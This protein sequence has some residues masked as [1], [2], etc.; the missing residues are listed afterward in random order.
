MN[1]Q[2]SE[3]IKN[4]SA[5]LA[6]FHQAVGVIAKSADNPFFKSKYADLSSILESIK[7]PLHMA[8]LVFT[9]LP[10]GTNELTTFL[11]DVASG[12]FFQST[13]SMTPTKNDP[14]GAGSA[15]TYARRYSLTAILGLQT[16]EDDDGNTASQPQNTQT[17]MASKKA[18]TENPQ[19]WSK[20]QVEEII[21]K[22]GWE[23]R[24]GVSKASNKSWFALDSFGQRG[25]IS[26]ETYNYLQ[27]FKK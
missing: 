21:A 1:I 17:P 3:S 12:E 25:W 2:Y 22:D 4:I 27:N 23:I 24:T 8:G 11:I 14:Q 26:E 18:Q 9:Q 5:S 6:T 10:S 19:K 16:E 15:L 20:E 13:L 7:E